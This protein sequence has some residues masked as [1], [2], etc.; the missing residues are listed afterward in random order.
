MLIQ[1]WR[2]FDE[3]ERFAREPSD[4]HLRAW[5]RFNKAVGKDGIVGSWHET[6]TVDPDQFEC[7]YGNMPLFGLGAAMEH[8]EAV[9]R[10]ETARLRLS[11]NGELS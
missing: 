2:S 9:G 3:L 6:Y 10:R 7:V 11:A 8:M 1:Y 4:P 5:Q